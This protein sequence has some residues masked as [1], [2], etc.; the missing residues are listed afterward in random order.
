MSHVV[1]INIQHLHTIIRLLSLLVNL[2]GPGCDLSVFFGERCILFGKVA[3]VVEC[4]VS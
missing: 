2:I 3:H 1:R 4:P